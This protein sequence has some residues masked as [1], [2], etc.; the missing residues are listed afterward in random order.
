[1]DIHTVYIQLLRLISLDAYQFTNIVS[2]QLLR[3]H[4]DVGKKFQKEKKNYTFF[5]NIQFILERQY[6]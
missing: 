1:V 5:K 2:S 6:L 4:S 3:Y